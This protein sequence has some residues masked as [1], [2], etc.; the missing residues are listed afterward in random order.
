MTV[1][2]EQ[3]YQLVSILGR[4]DKLQVRFA[5]FAIGNE[6]VQVYPTE[7]NANYHKYSS[8]MC[9]VKYLDRQTVAAAQH[10]SNTVLIDRIMIVTPVPEGMLTC[11]LL[12]ER[13]HFADDIPD[14]DYALRQGAPPIPGS[15][16]LP[17]SVVNQLSYDENG[18]QVLQTVDPQLSAL[19]LPP[20]PPLPG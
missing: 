16:Q 7:T 4:I 2:R 20:Y 10:L 1:T 15:R 17:P 19:G 12:C 18:Q 14:E 3:L 9:F 13:I 5:P 6:C 8:K 11:N